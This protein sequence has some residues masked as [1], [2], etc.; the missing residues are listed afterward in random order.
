MSGKRLVEISSFLPRCLSPPGVVRTIGLSTTSSLPRLRATTAQRFRHNSTSTQTTAE[1]PVPTGTLS[2]IKTLYGQ[3]EERENGD[4]E[5]RFTWSE[6]QPSYIT[7]AAENEETASHAF[8]VRQ[9]KSFDS[10][11][12]L[13]LHS[14]IIQSPWLKKALGTILSGYPGVT[15]E[16]DR[17]EFHAPFEPFIHRWG[18][19]LKFNEALPSALLGSGEEAIYFSEDDILKTKAHMKLLL[20]FLHSELKETTDAVVDFQDHGVCTYEHLWTIFQPG[21]VVLSSHSETLSGYEFVS[22]EY[23]C[24]DDGP[25]YQLKLEC[26]AWDGLRFGRHKSDFYLYE[27]KGMKD[28][29]K[30]KAYPLAFHPEK[31]QVR[32]RL[33]D[34]GKK[35][36][37]LAGYCYKA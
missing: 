29:T 18:N 3:E 7:E 16:L 6:K 26:I 32:H 14:I 9:K 20:E 1:K 13:D 24:T 11:R 19:I 21:G 31:E 35:A 28:I 5:V 34:R 23:L 2:S 4:D 8:I 12:G 30:L 37:E 17:L 27:F 10:R 36:E 33:V 25:A 15:C 22:G